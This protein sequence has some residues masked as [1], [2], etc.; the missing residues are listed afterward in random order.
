MNEEDTDR[1]AIKRK[2]D[3]QKEGRMEGKQKEGKKN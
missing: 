1:A 3:G 2:N